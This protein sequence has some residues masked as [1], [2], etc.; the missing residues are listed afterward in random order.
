M[1]AVCKY[2]CGK[3]YSNQSNCTRHE[4]RDNCVS[5]VIKANYGKPKIKLQ[6]KVDVSQ[7]ID[8]N[9]SLSIQL[10]MEGMERQIYDLTQVVKGNIIPI[11]SKIV[12]LETHLKTQQM[13]INT[14][15]NGI[16]RSHDEDDEEEE[17]ELLKE[18]LNEENKEILR[19]VN[20]SYIYV[21]EGM[22]MNGMR[23]YYKVGETQR[24]PIN[25]LKE[26]GHQN[27]LILMESV[28]DSIKSER[29]I[30]KLLRASGKLINRLDLGKEYFE[31]KDDKTIK[32]LIHDYLSGQ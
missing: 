3:S 5:D 27:R 22:D 30:L 14:L 24:H 1:S 8:E 10:K 29:E 31:C 23:R 16:N 32:G 25:R 15:R 9:R 17:H 28:T 18:F 19:G 13:S 12:E 4:T 11:L 26:H 6:L 7:I 21:I 20:H 2:G